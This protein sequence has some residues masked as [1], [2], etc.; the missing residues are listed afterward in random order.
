MNRDVII[1]TRGG[2]NSLRRMYNNS[3][4]ANNNQNS[5]HIDSDSFVN[6]DCHLSPLVTN[7]QPRKSYNGNNINNSSNPKG[8]LILRP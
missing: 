5:S 1:K 6:S 4:I 7:K 8:K 2:S 3:G